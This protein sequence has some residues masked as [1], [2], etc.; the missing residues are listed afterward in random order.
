MFELPPILTHNSV[1]HP[2]CKL[3]VDM[4]SPGRVAV[5]T[6]THD[7]R[8]RTAL[9]VPTSARVPIEIEPVLTNEL[10]MVHEV[11]MAMYATHMWM[12]PPVAITN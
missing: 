5:T 10:Q 11:L 9:S 2:P 12:I 4:G 3:V 1:V 6:S 7:S 8:I